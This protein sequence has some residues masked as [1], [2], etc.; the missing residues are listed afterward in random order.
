MDGNPTCRMVPPE[1]TNSDGG[2]QL[3]RCS[4]GLDDHVRA[5]ATKAFAYPR[6]DVGTRLDRAG[7]TEALG[8][9]QPGPGEVDH[10]D[11]GIGQ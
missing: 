6:N 3:S 8:A 7:G 2:V 4:A 10:R 1:R 5:T 11:V 9:L